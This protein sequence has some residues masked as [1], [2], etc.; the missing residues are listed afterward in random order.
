MVLLLLY[1]LK[2]KLLCHCSFDFTFYIHNDLTKM[3]LSHDRSWGILRFPCFWALLLTSISGEN[4]ISQSKE[5]E[6]APSCSR[7]QSS[8]RGFDVVTMERKVL[9]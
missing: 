2:V 6:D 3:F 1:N 7:T 5:C 9:M 8:W 4:D